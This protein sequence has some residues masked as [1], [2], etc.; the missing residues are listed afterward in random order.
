MREVV[1]AL[2]DPEQITTLEPVMR[3]RRVPVFEWAWLVDAF[4]ARETIGKDLIEDRVRNPV[5]RI[6]EVGRYL[7]PPTVKPDTMY[8]CRN[9]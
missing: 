5:R 8:F 6:L 4:A 7:T 1:E 3:G 2:D 9:R